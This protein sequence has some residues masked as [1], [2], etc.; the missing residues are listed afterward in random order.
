MS[1]SHV[2][3]LHQIW[4][5]KRSGLQAVAAVVFTTRVS[6]LWGAVAFQKRHSPLT[7]AFSQAKREGFPKGR[8][9]FWW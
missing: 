5:C 8:L 4:S 2:W 6:R 7:K 3:L 9:A 1:L